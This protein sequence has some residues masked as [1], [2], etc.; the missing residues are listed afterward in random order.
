MTVQITLNFRD[1]TSK[2]ITLSFIENQTYELT[3]QNLYDLYPSQNTIWDIEFLA[4]TNLSNSET[5]VSVKVFGTA[6]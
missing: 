4:Q 2:N 3:A 5:N 6:R 1:H